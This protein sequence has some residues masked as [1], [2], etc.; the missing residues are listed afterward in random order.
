DIL[1]A[2]RT[3]A[4]LAEFRAEFETFLELWGFRC[5]GELM[6]TV[7]SFQEDPARLIDVLKAYT[8]HDGTSPLDVLRCQEE[9]RT[10]ATAQLLQVLRRRT[11][12]PLLPWPSRAFLVDCLLT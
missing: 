1:V 4:E 2:I 10:V 9:E 6:L 3:R 8:A 5:S 11:L 12:L 7:A